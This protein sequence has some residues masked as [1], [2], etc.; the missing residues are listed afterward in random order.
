MPGLYSHTTRATGTILT[1]TIYNG[2][3]QNHI[4]NAIPSQHD[5]YS[6]N[7]VQMQANVD[8]GEV[9]SESLATSTAGEIERL[10]FA[11]KEIK[12][13]DQWYETRRTWEKI[14]ETVP[15]A[16]N[17]IC[18]ITLPTGYK[19]F[20]VHINGVYPVSSGAGNHLYFRARQGGSG[21][22]GAADYFDSFV[23]WNSAVGTIVSG[24]ASFLQLAAGGAT[25]GEQ[26]NGW[27]EFNESGAGVRMKF[28]GQ[29]RHVN[30]SGQRC[31]AILGGEVLTT[32]ARTDGFDFGWVGG[33]NFSAV[34]SFI[35]E[36]MR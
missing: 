8:P 22:A 31:I 2:D 17:S 19:I 28:N 1:A 34:G 6:V 32:T 20:R 25:T 4:D 33:T 36:G 18:T 3:H 13:T 21:I 7:V 30:N 29:T 10:R 16:G 23:H 5:D 9:G 26:T 35:L 12:G 24:T 14:S 15:L 11:I 27:F